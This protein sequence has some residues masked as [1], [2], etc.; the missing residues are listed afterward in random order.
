MKQIT[1]CLLLAVCGLLV[2]SALRAQDAAPAP[3]IIRLHNG[4]EITGTVERQPDGSLRVTDLSGNLFLFTP[5]EVLEVKKPV[6]PKVKKP[7]KEVTTKKGYMGIVEAAGGFN[8]DYIPDL[9]ISIDMINGYRFSP[10][11]YLG[12]GVGIR[13]GV[14]EKYV[15]FSEEDA[16]KYGWDGYNI[17]EGTV[18]IPVY[19]HVRSSFLR[20]GRRVSP[21]MAASFGY[22]VS[23]KVQFLGDVS[24]GMEIRL[25][26]NKSLWIAGCLNTCTIKD[27]TG[28]AVAELLEGANFLGKIGF[29]F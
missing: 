27:D 12:V 23:M 11:F 8:L 10:K 28:S 1:L 25:N 15:K 18:I 29:S 16:L 6:A 2:P 22:D 17:D 9:N 20:D 19:L 21:Y 24:L 3:S 4:T 14:Y 26:N 13:Y 5:D 7:K